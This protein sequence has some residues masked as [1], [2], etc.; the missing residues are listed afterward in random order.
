M[1]R[2]G[3]AGIGFMGMIHYL[4]YQKVRG[5][6]VVALCSRDE[7]KLAGDWTGIQGNF[8][9]RG[10]KMDLASV[11]KYRDFADLIND[12]EIDLI[13][14]CLPTE[15]HAPCS[16]QALS[17]GKHVFV[18]KPIALTA[19]DADTCL[20]AAK[21]AGKQLL[22]GHV[23][24]FFPEFNFALDFVQSEKGG[25]LLGAHL[26]R[27]ICKPTWRSGPQPDGPVVDL[28]IHDNHFVCLLTGTPNAV[29]CTGMIDSNGVVQHV[30]TQYRYNGPNQPCVT[31]SSGAL[32]QSGWPFSH[33]YTLYLERATLAYD[34][35]G[36][37]LTLLTHDGQVERV[38][39][40]GAGDPVEAFVQELTDVI[41]SVAEERPSRRLDGRLGRDAL[42]MSLCEEQAVKSGS[43]IIL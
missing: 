22:V 38:A 27:M 19:A 32:Y 10:T 13:D 20:E 37:P 6:K 43:E 33:G 36:I 4:A 1:V 34:S 11:K 5:A 42:V 25:K 31:A 18:E 17:A 39:T 3:I 2:V 26:R 14:I 7:N 41:R 9:P 8:G 12:P 24:P 29:R 23:L 21:R 35:L 15:F 16:R 28:H 30:E 40:P